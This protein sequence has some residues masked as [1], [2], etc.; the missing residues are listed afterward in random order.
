MA[1]TPPKIAT[2]SSQSASLQRGNYAE[3]Q[4]G[5]LNLAAPGTGLFQG[6]VK[7]SFWAGDGS[8]QA[9][10]TTGGSC[11]MVVKE[12]KSIIMRGAALGELSAVQAKLDG[13]G[14]KKSPQKNPQ[15]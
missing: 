2:C 15:N 14:L 9:A 10:A 13:I 4:S 5:A 3:I 1:K 6:W 7:A 11:V 12:P 8:G